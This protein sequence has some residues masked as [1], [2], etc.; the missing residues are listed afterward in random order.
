MDERTSQEYY[1]RMSGYLSSVM[2]IG[3]MLLKYG[4]EVSRVEDTMGRLCKAYGFV[5]SDV[6]TITSSIIATVTLSDERSITQT[7]RI[8]ERVTDLGR[9][10]RVNALSRKICAAPCS[11]KE[12]QAEVRTIQESPGVPNWL[13]LVMYAM[14]SAALSIFFGGVW[15]DGCA[16]ALSGL[17]LFVTLQF[18]ATL[19]LNS[20]IQTMI[21]SAITAL[22]VLLLVELGI[23]WQPDKIMIGNIMLV[24]PGIQFTT[25]LRDMINGDTIS[26]LL[27]MSEAVLKAISVAMGFAVVLIVGGG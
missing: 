13:N 18:S 10:A 7:R 16:A 8:K 12:L 3:E 24:I 17:V 20:I 2:D 5:R 1:E 21:C 4:A 14:I 25:A 27:N 15:M 26:G 6:F 9:V 19:K 23:G 22:A 11:L